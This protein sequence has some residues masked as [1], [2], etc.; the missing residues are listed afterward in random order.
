MG[1]FYQRKFFVMTERAGSSES[2]S[3]HVGETST[4]EFDVGAEL[5]KKTNELSEVKE[6]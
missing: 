3:V 1:L 6:K 5:K 4:E 2:G